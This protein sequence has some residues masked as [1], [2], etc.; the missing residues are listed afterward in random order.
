MGRGID[1]VPLTPFPLLRDVD[2]F[3]SCSEGSGDGWEGTWGTYMVCPNSLIPETDVTN[4]TQTKTP[5]H[6]NDNNMAQRWWRWVC[7]KT[8]TLTQWRQEGR[9]GARGQCTKKASQQWQTG[10]N[11]SKQE[12]MTANR[13]P[14]S[15]EGSNDSKPDPTTVN[16][17]QQWWMGANDSQQW[18]IEN[19]EGKSKPMKS[20]YYP[21]M[22]YRP[23]PINN[24]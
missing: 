17:S 16:R 23:H 12:P 7:P 21:S 14:R 19:K 22:P 9:N 13:I 18:Q 6:S 11:S 10:A 4:L 8:E 20:N 5:N 15:Q 3:R 1:C 24:K 2:R